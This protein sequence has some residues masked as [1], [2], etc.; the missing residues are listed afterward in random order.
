MGALE[1]ALDALLV[2]EDAMDFVLEAATMLVNTVVTQLVARHVILLA[3][4]SVLVALVV[5]YNK[6]LKTKLIIKSLLLGSI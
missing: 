3:L 2:L 4:A 5:Q 6:L 1:N